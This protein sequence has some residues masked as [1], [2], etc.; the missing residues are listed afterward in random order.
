M[1]KAL[2][3][4]NDTEPCPNGT[5]RCATNTFR[6]VANCFVVR[7]TRIYWVQEEDMLEVHRLGE[8]LGLLQPVQHRFRHCRGRDARREAQHPQQRR[9]P[10]HQ[11]DPGQ[12]LRRA[13]DPRQV[14]HQVL[15]E[16][17]YKGKEDKTEHKVVLPKLNPAAFKQLLARLTAAAATR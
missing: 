8:Q 12:H 1:A 16:L 6:E 2:V 4:G 5:T 11:G 10:G 7:D 15:D 17:V 3:R 13:Q 9:R 14:R